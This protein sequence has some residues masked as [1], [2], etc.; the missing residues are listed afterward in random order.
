MDWNWETIV[1]VTTALSHVLGPFSVSFLFYLQ[2][3]LIKCFNKTCWWL[4][5]KKIAPRCRKWLPVSVTRR[6]SPI[7]YK[8]C[9]K[10][11]F[12]KQNDKFWHLYKTCHPTFTDKK[13]CDRQCSS[14]S[15]FVSFTDMTWLTLTKSQC[16]SQKL[17]RVSLTEEVN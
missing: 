12:R 13:F 2:F 7:V 11:D 5:W 16:N 9:P 4:D 15:T 1:A 3:I 14:V 6:K 8:S 10:N 17:S